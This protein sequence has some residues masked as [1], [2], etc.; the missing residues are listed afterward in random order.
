[1]MTKVRWSPSTVAPRLKSNSCGRKPTVE[2]LRYRQI[3]DVLECT[4]D[5][6]KM[7]M[8]RARKRVR[9]A[10]SS[11]LIRSLSQTLRAQPNTN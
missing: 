5:A 8:H 1:M 7:R 4:E 2:G 11:Y 9:D 6:V 3:A 10:L